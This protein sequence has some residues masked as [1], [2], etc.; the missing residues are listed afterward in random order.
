ME[1][2]R[3]LRELVDEM[4]WQHVS[5][6]HK[7]VQELAREMKATDE[8]K[9]SVNDLMPW[10]TVSSGDG[11]LRPFGPPPSFRG[12]LGGALR[13]TLSAAAEES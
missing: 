4:N 12:G 10:R 6:D 3:E 7:A 13:A 11:P 8:S 5:M 1:E 2:N 9:I